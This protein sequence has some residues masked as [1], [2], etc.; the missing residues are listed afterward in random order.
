LATRSTN[1]VRRPWRHRL[2]V[3]AVT[4]VTLACTAESGDTEP[5][6]LAER[7]ASCREL[8]AVE[9]ATRALCRNATFANEYGTQEEC[10]ARR[11]KL[12]VGTWFA[13]GSLAGPG[14]VRACAKALDRSNLQTEERCTTWWSEELLRTTPDACKIA[15]QLNDGDDCVSASQCKSQSCRPASVC[16][17]CGL[18]GTSGAD[19]VADDECDQNLACASSKCGNYVSKNGD[20]GPSAPCGPDYGCDLGRCVTRRGVGEACDPVGNVCRL[21]GEELGCSTV[22]ETCTPLAVRGEAEDCG[23]LDDGTVAQCTHGFTCLADQSPERGVCV[24]L[25]EDGLSCA[26]TGAFVFS[27]PCRAPA[28]CIDGLCQLRIGAACRKPMP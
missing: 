2:G 18:L 22:T 1:A 23:Q 25:I 10:V 11:S 26:P 12:C 28:R 3:A 24:P 6:A 17:S 9:C 4:L 21:W 8:S 27:G 15:G 5:D 16:G 7:L 14:D 19:C 13:S 20:C